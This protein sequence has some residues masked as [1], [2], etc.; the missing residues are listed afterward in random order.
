M[1]RF[2]FPLDSVLAFRQRRETEQQLVFAAFLAKMHAAQAACDEY[3]ARRD[4]M[5][6]RLHAGHTAMGSDE[7]RMTYAHCDYLDRAIVQQRDVIEGMR[8]DLEFERSKLLECAKQRKILETLKERRRAAHA[9]EAA[10]LEQR[11]SDD[12]NARRY[13]RAH[14][15]RETPV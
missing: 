6:E 15:R 11:E 14:V 9:A 8:F 10:A 12:I 3:A 7:L 4:A 2:T 1:A 13:D 5:R